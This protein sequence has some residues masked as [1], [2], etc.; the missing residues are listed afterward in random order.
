MPTTELSPLAGRP[1]TPPVVPNDDDVLMYASGISSSRHI[2]GITVKH[3]ET[4]A[5]FE[6]SGTAAFIWD[7]LNDSSPLSVVK[8]IAAERHGVQRA[9][10][11][12]QI[13]VFIAELVVEGLVTSLNQPASQ[14]EKK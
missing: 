14:E 5:Y 8:D 13:D 11:S 12:E 6:L 10:I 1:S 3:L 9:A 2:D 7:H 4:G